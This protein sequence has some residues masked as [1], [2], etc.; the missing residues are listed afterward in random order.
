MTKITAA[1][2]AFACVVATLCLFGPSACSAD[3]PPG[4]HTY[5]IAQVAGRV[6]HKPGALAWSPDSRHLAFISG[7]VFLLDTA[8]NRQE[9]VTIPDPIF[10]SWGTDTTL[11]VLYR[12]LGQKKLCRID[13][14][15]LSRK[16]LPLASDPDAVFA[17]PD[18]G[19]LLFVSARLEQKRL[20]TEF[21][22][23]LVLFDLDKETGKMLYEAQK[24]LPLKKM[25]ETYLNGWFWSGIRP[26]DSAVLTVEP[27][28]PPVIMPY[29]QIGLVDY[30]TGKSRE[31]GKISNGDMPMVASWSPDG[32]RF[33]FTDEQRRM[34]IFDVG[35]SSIVSPGGGIDIAGV[36]PS[37][38]PK[39]S[40]IYFGG[41]ILRSD[42]QQKEAIFPG[43]QG[44]FGVWSPDGTKIAILNNEELHLLSGYRPSAVPPDK[45]YSAATVRK[46]Y[47]LKELLSEGLITA[48]EYEQRHDKLI[49]DR[50]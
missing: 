6:H 30:V 38:N 28:K 8:G 31:I 45:I 23:S 9:E 48:Q 26:A 15:S 34:A 3:L 25:D 14:A 47:L 18:S 41:Y 10:L 7:N 43:A 42:G 21:S 39:G 20:W 16:D 13:A 32:G 27:V 37:W 50:E 11:Y 24:R 5:T 35:N 1:L 19:G 33:A 36:Y 17:L 4:A 40:Q 46:L 49:R 2:C 29:L 44:S 12:E 22:Y